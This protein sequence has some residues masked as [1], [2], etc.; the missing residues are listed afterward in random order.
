MAL[1][2]QQN[3]PNKPAPQEPWTIK[4]LLNSGIQTTL[5]KAFVNPFD[6]LLGYL[7][8]T[9]GITEILNDTVSLLFWV[10]TIAIL[11]ASIFERNKELFFEIKQKEKPKK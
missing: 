3:I 5:S 2:N 6:I 4:S 11:G 9:F 8:L 1:T 7:I 10:L